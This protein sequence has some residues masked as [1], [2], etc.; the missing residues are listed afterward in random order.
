MQRYISGTDPI[1]FRAD[2]TI[3]C[4]E[5]TSNG[6]RCPMDYYRSYLLNP[7]RWVPH[8]SHKMRGDEKLKEG[9]PK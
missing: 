6:A 7:D 3:G 2:M 5:L 4:Q 9:T 8:F 1:F